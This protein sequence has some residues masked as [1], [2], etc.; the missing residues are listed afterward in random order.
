MDTKL[1][2]VGLSSFLFSR[3]RGAILSLLL[4][5]A[6]ESFYL[7]QIVR[8]VGYGLGPVQRELKLLSD[9]GILL[10][11]VSGHQVY[12]QANSASPIYSELKS[13]VIKT[14]GAAMVL[15]EALHPLADRISVAFVF[16]SI[17]IGSEKRDSDVDLFAIGEP[18]SLDIVRCLQ[19]AQMKLGREINP[20]VF[21]RSEFRAKLREKSHFVTSVLSVPKIFLIGDEDELKRLAEER[22]ARRTQDEPARDNRPSGRRRT[23]ST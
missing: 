10:R 14:V 5:H 21:P 18:S 17:A 16:G 13:L 20:V 9:A 12:F 15:R 3:T 6:D 23:G 2:G 7:R 19:A 11:S 8:T 1:G 22:V 4:G